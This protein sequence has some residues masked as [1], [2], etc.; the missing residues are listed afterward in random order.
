MKK[1]KKGRVLLHTE[2][3]RARYQHKVSGFVSDKPTAAR[4]VV[5]FAARKKLVDAV[6]VAKHFKITK[7]AAS[8]RLWRCRLAGFLKIEERDGKRVF[9]IAESRPEPR[10]KRKAI[11]PA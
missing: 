5:G 1:S 10:R 4:A 7:R 9:M 2:A 11:S 8:V 6:M 3:K